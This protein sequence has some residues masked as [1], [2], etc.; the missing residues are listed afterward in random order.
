MR[1]E[2]VAF[3][4]TSSFYPLHRQF[5]GKKTAI[6]CIKVSIAMVKNYLGEWKMNE[7]NSLN[8]Q[9]FFLVFHLKHR[10]MWSEWTRAHT[11]RVGNFEWA[12]ICCFFRPPPIPAAIYENKTITGTHWIN[13]NLNSLRLLILSVFFSF[14]LD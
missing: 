6:F 12:F 3:I 8:V 13:L 10:F 4:E 14:F 9:I 1:A 2:Q 11:F 5:E 7:N